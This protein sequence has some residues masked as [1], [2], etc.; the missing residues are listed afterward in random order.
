[1]FID[2]LGRKEM[3]FTA[4][5]FLPKYP[6]IDRFEADVLNPYNENFNEVIYK[7]KEFYENR[8]PATEPFPDE[9]G[10]LLKHQKIIAR[11]FSS[12]TPYDGIL[13]VHEMGT[14]KTCSAIG[15]IEQIRS[16]KNSGFKGALI[17]ARGE[18][19]LNNFQEELIF[20]CTDGRYI[21]EN[22]VKLTQGEQVRRKKKAI[23]DFYTF[24][25]YEVFAK[26]IDRSSTALL[27]RRYSNM[28][29]VMDEV[30]NVRL[31]DRTEG[32]K[33]YE[34]IEEFLHVIENSKKML[35]SGTPMKAPFLY[36]D[37]IRT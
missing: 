5:D 32:L 6:H 12:R 30:H 29:V 1:M 13:L 27:K 2:N 35:L 17:L 19:L 18:G 15:A 16:E 25:T 24:N 4:A 34:S 20:R 21:P 31:Q 7:K 11:Y 36:L 14:G 3:S 9:A 10:E 37:S 23:Q 26:E 8:L 33:V 28:I 22:Y